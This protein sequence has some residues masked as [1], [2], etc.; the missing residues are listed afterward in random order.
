MTTSFDKKLFELL[1]TDARFL[2]EEGELVKAAVID[3]T[4][5]IDRDLV[6]LLL[7]DPGTK[8]KFFAEIEGI[9]FSIST[10]SLNMFPTKI[11]SLTL[12]PASAT[13]L[14]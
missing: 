11:F 1:K 4:W 13:V 6:K 8:E 3:R 12:T 5:K 9:G 7:R 10:P 14:A 2:D